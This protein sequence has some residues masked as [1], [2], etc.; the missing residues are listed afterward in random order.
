MNYFQKQAAKQPLCGLFKSNWLVFSNMVQMTLFRKIAISVGRATSGITDVCMASLNE[1]KTR[2]NIVV[3]NDTN[4]NHSIC[5]VKAKVLFAFQGP[6]LFT[7]T[8]R[9]PV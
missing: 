6:I 7:Y 4:L 5:I 2:L 8:V 9:L 1:V 3:S